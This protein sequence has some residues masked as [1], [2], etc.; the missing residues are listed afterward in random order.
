MYVA[1]NKSVSYEWNERFSMAN[2]KSLY[3]GYFSN[4]FLC[5]HFPARHSTDYKSIPNLTVIIYSDSI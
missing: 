4:Q 1:V 3:G 5:L 2:G